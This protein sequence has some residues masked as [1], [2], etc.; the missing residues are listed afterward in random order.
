MTQAIAG[1]DYE[2]REQSPASCGVARAASL[3]R[4]SRPNG[5]CRKI[6]RVVLL[7][8]LIFGQGTTGQGR[9]CRMRLTRF[10]AP[11]LLKEFRVNDKPNGRGP[12][13]HVSSH[14][15]KVIRKGFLQ[16][17]QIKVIG[18]ADHQHIVV[19]GE[20]GLVCKPQSITLGADAPAER[21]PQDG[22]GRTCV[23]CL[24]LRQGSLP[25]ARRFLRQ[26]A[27]V[28]PAREIVAR[29]G[30]KVPAAHWRTRR[31]AF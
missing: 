29:S 22:R 13:Q 27:V 31:G 28:K 12:A 17:L 8:P 30:G 19:P 6:V 26:I 2:V 23:D 1:A 11:R 5:Q 10:L 7:R 4:G 21:F 15:G 14:R 16:P 3:A 18:H 25:G 9:R 20:F 24:H